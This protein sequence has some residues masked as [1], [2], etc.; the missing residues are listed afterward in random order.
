[1]SKIKNIYTAVLEYNFDDI[2]DE[3]NTSWED[4]D[5]GGKELIYNEEMLIDT[6]AEEIAEEID[7]SNAEYNLIVK[8]LT[9]DETVGSYID[10]AW[11]EYKDASND[12]VEMEAQIHADYINY[13]HS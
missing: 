3:T 7:A 2:F 13:I 11:E 10:K 6:I 8:I 12:L 5:H 4:D 1:M 9:E